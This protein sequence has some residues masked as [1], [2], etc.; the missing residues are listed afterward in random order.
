MILIVGLGNPGVRYAYTRHNIGFMAVDYIARRLN[1][2]RFL[3]EFSSLV[4]EKLIEKE[5]VII[6]KPQ[7]FM[8]LSGGAVQ[9]IV[10]FYKIPTD[11]VFVIHDDID[12][13]LYDIRI[14]YAG[15]NGGHNGLR[16]IDGGVGKNYWRIRIGIG[17]PF[18]KNEVPDY[19]LSN[20]YKNELQKFSI[21]LEFLAE[22]IC[23]L[24]FKENKEQI[25]QKIQLIGK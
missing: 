23:E 19:V 20:F 7:T 1:F 2:S 3:S 14:K 22:N 21:I 18:D 12:L 8:N 11:C 25:I 16:S 9:K 17:R 15:G 4:S 13:V 10:S 24:I 5:K 6:Q